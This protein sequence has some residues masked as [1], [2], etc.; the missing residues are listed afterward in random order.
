M[1]REKPV[2]EDE[3]MIVKHYLMGE[4]IRMFDGPFALAESAKA[5]IEYGLGYDFYDKTIE[6]IKNTTAR[7]LLD[8][9]NQYLDPGTFTE[10]VAGKY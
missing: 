6:T 4:L 5:I 1:L 9:A 7:Q 8:L 3:L 10:V 2:P